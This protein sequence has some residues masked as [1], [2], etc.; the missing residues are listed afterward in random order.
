M[1]RRG[2]NE[3]PVIPVKAWLKLLVARRSD[4]LDRDAFTFVHASWSNPL[5][6]R[7]IQPSG[8]FAPVAI[9]L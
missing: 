1:V 2:T 8:A 3:P 7:V 5:F 6:D 4:A 9:T